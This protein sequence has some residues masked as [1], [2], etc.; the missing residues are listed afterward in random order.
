MLSGELFG[1]PT[2]ERHTGES[3][4]SYWPSIDAGCHGQRGNHPGQQDSL[5]DA[6]KMWPTARVTTNGGIPCPAH[7]GKGSRLEDEA[8]LWATPKCPTGGPESTEQKQHRPDAGAGDLQAQTR[9]WL[10]PRA[11]Y[12]EH[13]GMVDESHLTGQAQW[14]TPRGS[15]WKGTGPEGSSSHTH[16]LK[17]HYPDAEAE[18]FRHGLP[19]PATATAGEMPWLSTP[20]PHPHCH[21]LAV[22]LLR[23]LLPDGSTDW[24]HLELTVALAGKR[25]VRRLNPTF[26][27]WLMGLPRGWTNFEPAE[28]ASYLSRQRSLLACLL[29]GRG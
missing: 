24:S 28:T 10:T 9:D 29:N 26:V 1:R 15:E 3:E 14:A 11:I 7:A 4:S 16:R 22:E 8:A 17:R 19:A 13:P 18:S 12:A 2:W 6:A 20:M 27:E 21:R 5:D 23:S 25:V